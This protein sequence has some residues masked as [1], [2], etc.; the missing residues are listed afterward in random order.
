MSGMAPRRTSVVPVSEY[1]TATDDQGAWRTQTSLVIDTEYRDQQKPA[2][3]GQSRV[4][5]VSR[6]RGG[7]GVCAPQVHSSG[8]PFIACGTHDTYPCSTL[9]GVDSC[10]PGW[11]ARS[12]RATS[13]PATPVQTLV[14]LVPQRP[15]PPFL[16]A[17][18]HPLY[19]HG[20]T[21]HQHERSA[22]NDRAAPSLNP[23]MDRS[24]CSRAF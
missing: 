4:P 23:V 13:Q 3:P 2:E 10:P 7:M 11:H 8:M 14:V 5:C 16:C 1:P 15:P 21:H 9:V 17:E 12:H 18:L 22:T 6:V 24:G 19:A 20:L